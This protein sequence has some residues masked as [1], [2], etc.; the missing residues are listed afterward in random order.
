MTFLTPLFSALTA[1]CV[2]LFM[3]TAKRIAKDGMAGEDVW[4]IALLIIQLAGL[5]WVFSSIEPIVTGAI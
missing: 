4:F 3:L 2:W 1:I 5:L